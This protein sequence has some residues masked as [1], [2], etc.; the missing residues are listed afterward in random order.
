MKLNSCSGLVLAALGALTI[1]ASLTLSAS[2]AM[3]ECVTPDCGMIDLPPPPPLPSFPSPPPP[4]DSGPA[5]KADKAKAQQTTSNDDGG[6]IPESA[7]ER[8]RRLAREEAEAFAM[9]VKCNGE[10][11]WSVDEDGAVDITF[12]GLD[13]DRK[14]QKMVARLAGN[15]PKFFIVSPRTGALVLAMYKTNPLPDTASARAEF[16]IDL[17]RLE[18]GSPRFSLQPW[19]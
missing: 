10:C 5:P 11:T 6:V 9:S 18:R 4:V 17:N 14:P 1:G 13:G 3:A 15:Q 2:P 8:K 12:Y 19:Q 16:L 7:A